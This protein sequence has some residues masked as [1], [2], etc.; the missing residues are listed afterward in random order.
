[1]TKF[2]LIISSFCILVSSH[3]F[4]QNIANIEFIN[5][6]ADKNKTTFENGI[7]FFM[8]TAGKKVQS[9]EDNMK[10]LNREG[11][12]SGINYSKESPLKR[13]ALAL[14]IARY[15]KLGDSIFYAIFKTE[16]YAYRACAA[17]NI[18]SYDGS[19]WDTLHGSELIEIMTKVS[20]LTGG[21]E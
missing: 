18:M 19:E 16:R 11:I 14:M 2:A 15:L 4:A 1:M 13:G 7:H 20:E 6:I 9:F 12:T 17:N 3:L 5:N 21:D 8:L 10:L